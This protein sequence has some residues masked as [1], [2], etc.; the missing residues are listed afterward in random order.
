MHAIRLF[1]C[2]WFG[3]GT[4]AHGICPLDF[5][6]EFWALLRNRCIWAEANKIVGVVWAHRLWI[7]K[8]EKI[9]GWKPTE[10]FCFLLLWSIFVCSPFGRLTKQLDKWRHVFSMWESV[11]VI[12]WEKCYILPPAVVY[13][14]EVS[15]TTSVSKVKLIKVTL[16]KVHPL[17]S[18]AAWEFKICLCV[19]VNFLLW[20]VTVHKMDATLD[21]RVRMDFSA[22]LGYYCVLSAHWVARCTP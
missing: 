19:S 14:K 12:R 2:W 6:P 1:A 4:L 11:S 15:K 7:T 10:A 16:W 5:W 21:T 9:V 8:A 18:G 22:E 17:I 3:D 13:G 20:S